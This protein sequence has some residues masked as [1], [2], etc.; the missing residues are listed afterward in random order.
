[1]TLPNM[2]IQY[3]LCDGSG[4]KFE[5]DP[6]L[7]LRRIRIRNSLD[8]EDRLQ[9]WMTL[10]NM[11]IRYSLCYRSGSRFDEDPVIILM[12]PDPQLI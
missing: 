7:S 11:D 2:D 6:V 3:S 8:V 10:P 9:L 4:S 12:D 1:M 5:K